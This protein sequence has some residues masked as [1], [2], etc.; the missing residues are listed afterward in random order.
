MDDW[1]LMSSFCYHNHVFHVEHVPLTEIAKRFSTPC[2]VYSRSM[3]EQK[4]R[5]FDHALGHYPHSICYAVKANSNLAILNL[6]ARLGSGFDVV[7]VGELERV[8][9]AGAD[10]RHV[11]FSGVAKREDEILRALEVGIGCFHVESEEELFVIHV[12]ASQR[13]Q[14]APIALRI[15]PDVDPKT[16]PYIATG[17]KENKFGIPIEKAKALYQVANQ[18]PFVKPTGIACHIGSQLTSLE[19]FEAVLE[20]LLILHQQLLEQKIILQQISLGGGLGVRYRDEIIPEIT[21][22]VDRILS[23][24]QASGL[25]L[26][27]EPGRAIAAN[28]GILLTQVIQ[29]KQQGEHRFV[30]IDAGMNDLLRPALYQAWHEI[31]PVR[32]DITVPLQVCDVVGPICETGDFMGKQRKLRVKKN[33]LL[34]ICSAGAYGATMSSRYNS[35]PFIPEVLVDGKQADLVRRPETIDDMLRLERV[36][37]R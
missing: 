14:V 16:H 26:I 33:D 20:R 23:K 11:V 9:V 22:Y 19:P 2:Y 36:L 29:I 25:R 21:C 1:P 35:R 24:L 34:A 17:L 18:L 37:D 30:L 4:W 12:L 27:I 28:S 8:L 13:N 6:L 7:S 5:A 32:R 31:L 10:P 3:F 15:N